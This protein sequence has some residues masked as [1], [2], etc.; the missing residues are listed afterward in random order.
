[1]IAEENVLICSGFNT[2][3]RY[4]GAEEELQLNTDFSNICRERGYQASAFCALRIA[5][6]VVV[7]L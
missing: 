6:T 7:S 2:G 5:C 4:C 3:R 1:M